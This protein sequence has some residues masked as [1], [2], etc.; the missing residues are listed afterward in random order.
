MSSATG[1]PNS[2]SLN[3]KKAGRASVFIKKKTLI[4]IM[5]IKQLLYSE[6][7]TIAGAKKKMNSR[8][9]QD[10]DSIIDTAKRELREIL[11]ILK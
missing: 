2:R 9:G 11:D 8:A 1:R 10:I 3:P 6:G 4:R 5:H 7:Y